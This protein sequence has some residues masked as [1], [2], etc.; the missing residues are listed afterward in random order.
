MILATIWA[1]FLPSVEH[2]VY[3]NRE[4][5]SSPSTDNL[6]DESNT[7]CAKVLKVILIPL[8]ILFNF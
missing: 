4:V 8:L 3:F 2:S 1:F 6:E 7:P 5:S